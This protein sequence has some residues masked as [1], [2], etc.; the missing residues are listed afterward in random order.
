LTSPYVAVPTMWNR[1]FGPFAATPIVSPTA[2]WCF[3]A[4][5]ASTTTWCGPVAHEPDFS[6]SGLKRD[7]AGSIP[8]P[9]VGLPFDWIAFPSRSI[10]FARVESP[11]RSIR[12]PAA[13][14]PS[15]SRL[16]RFSSAGE[17]VALPLFE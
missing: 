17:T 8:K 7:C 9:K 12:E 11:F 16:I 13:A 10:R 14:S 2:K 6:F 1:T 15:G 4:V 3:R 5:S